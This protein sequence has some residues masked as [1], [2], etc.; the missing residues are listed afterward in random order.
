MD[1]PSDPS[2]QT[3]KRR[4]NAGITDSNSAERMVGRLVCL[5]RVV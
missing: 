1:P 5:L 2:S 3:V 4:S